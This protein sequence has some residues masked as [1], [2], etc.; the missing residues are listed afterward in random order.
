MRRKSYVSTRRRVFKSATS[1]LVFILSWCQIGSNCIC[2]ILWND[3]ETAFST[4]SSSVS[5]CNNK[6]NM[7]HTENN[8]LTLWLLVTYRITKPTQ[9]SYFIYC[10]KVVQNVIRQVYVQCHDIQNHPSKHVSFQSMHLD[11]Q[12]PVRSIF[13]THAPCHFSQ[14][15]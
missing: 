13:V 5:N 2:K 3:L 14:N 11:I 12:C 8:C 4:V 7:S 1:C 6:I 9:W 15:L 10:V